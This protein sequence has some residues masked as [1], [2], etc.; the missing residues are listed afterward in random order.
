MR[1]TDP[2]KSRYPAEA[3]ALKWLGEVVVP[4]IN[5]TFGSVKLEKLA[6]GS[7][8]DARLVRTKDNAE[9][10]IQIESSEIPEN[11]KSTEKPQGTLVRDTYDRT[12]WGRSNL[13]STVGI[14][15]ASAG[16]KGIAW[17]FC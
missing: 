6:E 3:R 1:G 2:G 16:W 14:N 10:L 7:F 4:I 11:V 12:Y 17:C 13:T 5:A 8:T 9:L 15:W